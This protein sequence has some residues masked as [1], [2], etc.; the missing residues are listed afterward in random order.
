MITTPFLAAAEGGFNPLH[1]DPTA[2]I[3][4][5][6]T[7]S[8]LFLILWK[9]AW[10][11][12]LSAI[13][14]REER[15]DS[16]IRDAETDRVQ[17]K[18]MLDDYTQRVANVESEIAALRE[19]GRTDAETMA[20][21]IR[22]KADESAKQI[23]EKATRDIELARSQALEDIRREAVVLGL[24]VASKVVERSVDDEDQRRLAEQV[25]AEMATVG[26]VGRNGA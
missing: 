23:A 21:D 2:A 10:G 25:V 6:V 1:M 9:F 17:A 16:A 13:E 22:A 15:I 20:K 3:L 4:T 19:K 7:F 12:I 11:P 24:A 14:A 5:L 26:P 8:G 18:A